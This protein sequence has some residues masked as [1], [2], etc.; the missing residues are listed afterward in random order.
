VGLDGFG[1]KEQLCCDLGFGLAVDDEPG[2][3]M[4]AFGQRLGADAGGLA[5]PSASVDVM[6]EASELV[7]GRGAVSEC[8]VGVKFCGGVLELGYHRF[9][10]H[11]Q[12]WRRDSMPP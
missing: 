5:W 9:C 8:S 2:D 10:R 1:G 3:L 7:L 6:A 4:R 11:G 12:C